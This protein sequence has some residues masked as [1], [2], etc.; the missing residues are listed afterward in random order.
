[1]EGE[2]LIQVG[3]ESRRVRAGDAIL[4]PRY[5]VH[6]LRNTGEG[7]LAL[8]CPVSPPW[9]PEDYHLAEGADG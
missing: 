2:G 4:I 3:G 8:I 6:T 5:E 7:E 9:Y 1:M